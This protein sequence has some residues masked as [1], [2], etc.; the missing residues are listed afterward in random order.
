VVVV[1]SHS[2][3]YIDGST[4][5]RPYQGFLSTAMANCLRPHSSPYLPPS[6]SDGQTDMPVVIRVQRGIKW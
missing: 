2:V 4:R 5:L 3:F 1:I 6:Q